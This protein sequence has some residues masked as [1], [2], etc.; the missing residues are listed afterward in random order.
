MH[1][2]KTQNFVKRFYQTPGLALQSIPWDKDLELVES[3]PRQDVKRAEDT[4]EW[5]GRRDWTAPICDKTLKIQNYNVKIQSLIKKNATF[6]LV[7]FFFLGLRE[8]HLENEGEEK[9]GRT[10]G[11]EL[12]VG[13]WVNVDLRRLKVGLEME[14]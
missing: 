6:F 13:F 12:E 4:A 2:N 14:R 1:W 3:M 8:V 7:H 10:E 9:E 11:M 5:S